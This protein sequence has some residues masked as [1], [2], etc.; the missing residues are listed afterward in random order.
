MRTTPLR[1]LMQSLNQSINRSIGRRR[2]R[3][4]R[5]GVARS[6]HVDVTSECAVGRSVDR[7]VGR[8][9]SPRIVDRRR[10]SSI[11]VVD[12]T[13]RVRP[14]SCKTKP[15]QTLNP[16][17]LHAPSVAIDP[18]RARDRRSPIADRR[19]T[20]ARSTTAR[21][22]HRHRWRWRA[23]DIDIDIVDDVDGRGRSTSMGEEGEGVMWDRGLDARGRDWSI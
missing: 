18:P 5:R 2:R 11:V 7:S 9:Y 4:R 15:N 3:R 23:I 1:T 6:R 16:C 13:S 14:V 17:V 20:T 21:D 10:S 8:V 19:S 12:G 22:R